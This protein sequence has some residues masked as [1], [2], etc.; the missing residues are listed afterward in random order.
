MRKKD[1][2][3]TA[4]FLIAAAI[5][6]LFMN[7]VQEDV[8]TGEV[9]IYKDGEVME[10]VPLTAEKTVVI[11]DENGN[12]NVV[13]VEGGKAEMT[14]A[15]CRDQVC[16]NTRPARKSGESVIC[17]PNRVVVEIRSTTENVIDG[18]SE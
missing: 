12:R 1:I 10:V 16:V 9:V 14:E 6:W 4:V 7:T 8:G 11:E 17:L 2:F 5:L 3:L 15:N 18:V 13:R